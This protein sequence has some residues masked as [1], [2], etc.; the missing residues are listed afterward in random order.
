M[1]AGRSIALFVLALQLQPAVLPAFCDDARAA[2]AAEC[3]QL[4]SLTHDERTLAGQQGHAPCLNPAL[5]GI[6]QPATPTS[7]VTIPLFIGLEALGTA[8]RIVGLVPATMMLAGVVTAVAARRRGELGGLASAALAW[9]TLLL[10]VYAVMVVAL[11]LNP[12][13][14]S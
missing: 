11:F 1:M 5:C 9:N 3:D 13:T 7:A 4:M 10:I 2:Q 8:V 14:P 12:V 6:V